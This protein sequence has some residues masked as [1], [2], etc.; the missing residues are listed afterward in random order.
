MIEKFKEFRL[1]FDEQKEEY[2]KIKDNISE[3]EK[4]ILL[5]E[6][7]KE[8]TG[9]YFQLS[10]DTLFDLASN[11]DKY[12]RILENTF[13]KVK[14]DMASGSFFEM[15]IKIGEEKKEIGISIYNKIQGESKNDELKIASGLILGGYSIKEKEY[16]DDLL[17]IKKMEYPLTNT[18][19]KT[20][21]VLYE[22]E[23][24][25]SNE[26]YNFL[27]LASDSN[28]ELIL[29][30]LVNVCIFLYAKNKEYFYNLIKKIII[31][32][33]LRSVGRIFIMDKKVELSKSQ[34]IELANLTKDYDEFVLSDL[35]YSTINYPRD[36][37]P[38]SELLIYWINKDLEFKINNL[39]W[40]I[41]E[42]VKKNAKFI[43]YFLDNF[44]KVK[45]EKVGYIHIFPRIFEKMA[46]QNV[47]YTSKKILEKHIEDKD[48]KL[49]YKLINKIIGIIYNKDKEKMFSLFLPLAQRIE[50]VAKAKDFIN[51]DE[52]QFNKLVNKKNFDELINYIYRLL[53]QLIFRERI[54]AELDFNEIDKSLSKFSKLNEITKKKIKELKQNKRYSSLFWFCDWKR[55][56]G[57]KIAYL[58]EF[59]D[60]LKFTDCG[61]RRLL[62][63]LDNDEE[64]WDIFS[65]YIFTNRFLSKFTNKKITIQSKIPNK[66]NPTDLFIK[67]EGRNVFFEIKNSRGDRSLHLDN[68]AVTIK[69]KL[70]S[71]LE[72]KSNQFYSETTLEEM[73]DGKRK[74]LFFIVVDTSSSIIDE[75]M[76]AD[77]FFGTLAY[78]FYVNK[79]TGERTGGQTIRQ[80]DSPL[81]DDKK[82]II[83]GIIYFK[84]QLVNLDGGTRFILVGDIIANPYAFN[85]PSEEEIKKLRE[86]IFS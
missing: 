65:E 60:F 39:D 78:Q 47:E 19:L 51:E 58:K 74:D 68:G 6:I 17:K 7:D 57:S 72:E 63:N 21:L 67:L 73:K 32:K 83:S 26:V 37:K 35:M 20:I 48:E 42:L 56:K 49:F 1:K 14:G 25:L 38:I 69:N 9:D 13:L 86:I 30:E 8:S 53:E 43:D 80:D 2:S 31:K 71:I 23:K 28:E 40:A 85:L 75:Y 61:R 24:E 44:S 41:Q 70:N 27:N 5:D 11:S 45:T 18:I 46:S 10:V 12:L 3:K 34:F 36:V 82:K 62:N 81:K 79:K 77:S 66:T 22:K 50:H 55:D 64:F 59:E 76:V 33:K 54:I 84:K 29:T 4:Y 16:L 15:L 52:K